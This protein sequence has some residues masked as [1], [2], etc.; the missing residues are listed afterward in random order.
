M[1]RLT[2]WILLLW[3]MRH[4]LVKCPV[5]KVRLKQK[6]NLPEVS[7]YLFDLTQPHDYYDDIF[8]T[9]GRV[10]TALNLV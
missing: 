2:H 1:P 7:D 6:L 3:E 9:K 10:H 5:F 8:L 4:C